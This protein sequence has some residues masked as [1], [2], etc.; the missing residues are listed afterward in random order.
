MP[1]PTRAAIYA[2]YSSELQ[3]ARSIEDQA[4]LCR[5]YAER[6]GY[7]IAGEYA[8]RA[9]S[10]ASMIG[11]DGLLRMIED[12][13]VGRFDL[14]LVESLD[15]ISRDM[16][17]LAAIHKRLS[18]AG[19]KL[20]TVG[21]GIANVITV[22]LRGIVGQLYLSDLKE[23]VRRGMAGVVREGRFAGGRAYGYR[24]TPGEPGK[25]VIVPEEADVIR[26]I[27]TTY[28]AGQTPREIA[29]GLN[30]DGIRPPRGARWNAST[31][32]GSADREN[33]L[34]RNAIYAGRIVWGKATMV[35]DP[36]TGKRVS[37]P[38]EA[39][40]RQEADAPALRIIDEDLFA[41]VQA[42]RSGR[43][44]HAG[45]DPVVRS[46]RLLSGLLRCGA[47]GGAMTVRGKDRGGVR[48]GCSAQHEAGVCD[49]GRRYYAHKIEHAVVDLLRAQLRHPEAVAAYLAAYRE[50]RR[51]EAD[52]ATRDRSRVER[53][54]SDVKASMGRIVD[55]IASG[56]LTAEEARSRLDPLRAEVPDLE[57][58]LAAADASLHVVEL[59]PQ[60]V[61]RYRREIDA[62]HAT[63]SA[64]A[65]EPGVAQELRDQIAALVDHVV[66][67]PAPAGHI[68]VE[69]MGRLAALTGAPVQ[70]SG[71]LSF[72]GVVAE[73]RIDRKKRHS[74]VSFGRIAR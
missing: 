60:A 3:N 32:N 34:L 23:K 2:R 59:H 25:L 33:G 19:V 52:A 72:F 5:A 55:A 22:G 42:R 40:A 9:R 66:V 26:R 73:A 44:R 45:D 70:P 8:D 54:L 14:I 43:K 74:G 27:F 69:V 30:K 28:D 58:R 68:D 49:H 62:I 11:R 50:E 51:A 46:K 71:R 65:K 12:S 7:S 63:L 15:R 37:R 6:Q 64:M 57:A 47:C 1:S 21:E 17:D 18:F 48:I 36:D 35:R 29:A 24:P 56:A 39:S 10:G 13:K 61:N 31:I 16:E 67:Y 20:E 4:A 41:R 38:G 53:R